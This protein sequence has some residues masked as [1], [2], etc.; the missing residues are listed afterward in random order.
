M[1]VLSW[2]VRGLGSQIKH[3]A[4]KS[5]LRKQRVEM[6][7]LVD[8]KLELVS[9]DVVKSIWW[10]DVF[11]YE[12]VPSLGSSGGILVIWE[13]T[14]FDLMGICHDPNFLRLRG[15]WCLEAWECD[16]VTVYAPWASEAQA[17]LVDVP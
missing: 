17:D 6:T 11:R 10:T 8:P 1:C 14:K 12:F 9:D 15:T 5:L 13:H 16:M 7:F 3:K 2:N 4:I